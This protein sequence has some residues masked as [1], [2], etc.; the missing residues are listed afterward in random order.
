[1]PTTLVSD[2]L[3]HKP[4]SLYLTAPVL[5]Q[6]SLAKLLKSNS[7]A[8]KGVA[9]VEWLDHQLCFSDSLCRQRQ[10]PGSY[11][12]KGKRGPWKIRKSEVRNSLDKLA[13][14]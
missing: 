5:A 1:M 13:T 14:K 6:Q 8:S 2:F 9:G 10:I 12:P 7:G 11:Q 3:P 4:D